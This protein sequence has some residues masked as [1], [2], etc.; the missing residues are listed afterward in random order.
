[1]SIGS[2]TVS[3]LPVTTGPI[4]AVQAQAP[5][6]QQQ[7]QQQRNLPNQTVI[8]ES[9]NLIQIGNGLTMTAAE[10]R[11]FQEKQQQRQQEAFR[12]GFNQ[13]VRARAP[14]RSMMIRHRGPSG[15][16]MVT[17]QSPQ[18]QS[19][20]AIPPITLP[21]GQ[22]IPIS[23]SQVLQQ[24]RFLQPVTQIQLQQ[25]TP[26]TTLKQVQT[27]GPQ[28][29][30]TEFRESARMLV[31]LQSGEQRL[32][33]FTLPKESCTVQDLLE[34]VQVQYSPD[35]NIQCI[36]NPG[37]DVDYIVTVGIGESETAEVIRQAEITLRS[38]SIQLHH[39]TLQSQP[40]MQQQQQLQQ[41]QQQQPPQ[42]QQPAMMQQTT[43]V[44]QQQQPQ[45]QQQTMMITVHP[46][47]QQAPH[48]QP[49]VLSRFADSY[50][51]TIA[52]GTGG[53]P[54]SVAT[55]S[56]MQSLLQTSTTPDTN[57]EVKQKIVKGFL[58]VCASCGYTGLDHAKC[59]RCK[60]V[61]TE[62]PRRVPEHDKASGALTPH[63][64]AG[65]HP[66]PLIPNA[67]STPI[68]SP[69]RKYDIHGKKHAMNSSVVMR[70][71][72]G[73]SVRSGRGRGRAAVAPKYQDI[74]PPVFTLSSEEED[75]ASSV[76]DRSK[77]I[78]KSAIGNTS[79]ANVAQLPVKRDPLPCEP[80][81]SEIETS[82]AT[83][84]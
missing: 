75:D 69:V 37:G 47:T 24:Q 81:T 49:Q 82:V 5:E 78:Y 32:I 40:L 9:N 17:I 67:T 11:T 62:E 10:F 3:T 54:V 56:H 41:Q 72:R 18:N 26:T 20:A 22:G 58:A 55:S 80:V 19:I 76:N 51:Q 61:F 12:G 42:Q 14:Q 29:G 2:S 28:S 33:T 46:N 38:Q 74:E 31:I 23:T 60:R 21:Q 71:G 1:E 57:P 77:T 30:D 48:Q 52:L 44:I 16:P 36:S 15:R 65:N 35:S 25:I 63:S 4:Y 6:Q 59:Q 53:T 27:I 45:P 79:K 39:H 84:K 83:G 73:G 8:D 50:R 7:Q 34:Q 64:S 43:C 66:P 70:S 68:G 13:T